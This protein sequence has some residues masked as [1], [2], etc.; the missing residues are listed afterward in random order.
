MHKITLR[1]I[2]PSEE[3]HSTVELALLEEKTSMFYK[4]VYEYQTHSVLL[5]E[6]N[7]FTNTSRWIFHCSRNLLAHLHVIVDLESP[8]TFHCEREF[9]II[10][11]PQVRLLLS[12]YITC[13][14]ESDIGPYGI[15][16]KSASIIRGERGLETLISPNHSDHCE[17]TL[18][19]TS[20]SI[21]PHSVRGEWINGRLLKGYYEDGLI[22]ALIREGRVSR[23]ILPY[24]IKEGQA[25]YWPRG[26]VL[27][28]ALHEWLQSGNFVAWHI[29]SEIID[30][31]LRQQSIEGGLLIPYITAARWRNIYGSPQQLH[32]FES[33]YRA[34][35]LTGINM[36]K[37][38]ALRALECYIKQPPVCLGYYEVNSNGGVFFRWGS[39]HYLSTDPEKRENLY[40]L[41]THLMGVVGLLEGW[42]LEKCEWCRDYAL[43]GI[44]GLKS[45]IRKFSRSDGYLYYSLHSKRLRGLLED[46]LHSRFLGYHTLSS[47]LLLRAA[48]FL[49]DE[50]LAHYGE[51]GC[52]YSFN[53]YFNG[54]KGIEAELLKCLVELYRWKRTIGILSIIKSI[55]ELRRPS[56]LVLGYS[57]D[58]LDDL[59]VIPPG[60][61]LTSSDLLTLLLSAR[62]SELEYYVY[63]YSPVKLIIEERA[64]PCGKDVIPVEVRG[65]ILY[66]NKEVQAEQ[67][68]NGFK[69]EI[70]PE[71]PLILH[72]LVE[73]E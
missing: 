61:M 10:S 22:W 54:N 31:I 50:E 26:D 41:N 3:V 29:Y 40:V 42:I 57:L 73:V 44:R 60:F 39:Y 47:K 6:K 18:L 64:L 19:V 65:G 48:N 68:E 15:V 51:Q 69:L 30:Q 9:C 13:Y 16:S 36:L 55:V 21:E 49:S 37:E 58:E 7:T 67:V 4:Q 8:Y 5:L 62:G 32:I 66:E 20:T 71:K 23:T 72:V 35:Q 53:R 12:N 33:L 27:R 52:K 24:Y 1:T 34:Y 17:W 45:L 38:K 63:A 14:S 46:K 2:I 28:S 43:K 25:Y 56:I 70:P 11:T 59:S